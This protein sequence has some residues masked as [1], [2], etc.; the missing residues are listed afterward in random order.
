MTY[1]ILDDTFCLYCQRKFTTPRRLQ[2]HIDSQHPYTYAY[3]AIR[4]EKE[5]PPTP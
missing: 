2:R 5:N 4:R 1:N 3:W